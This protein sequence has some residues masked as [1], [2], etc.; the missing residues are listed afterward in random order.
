MK[1]THKSVNDRIAA[2]LNRGQSITP[3][4]A[5]A[6]FGTFRLAARINNLRDAG[7]NIETERVRLDSGKSI[8][9]YK[10]AR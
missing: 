3:V 8:A 7:M 1:T 5:L 10:L 2:L 6:K 9:K 4:Q